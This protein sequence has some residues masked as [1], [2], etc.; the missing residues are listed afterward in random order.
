[1]AYGIAV[2][3]SPFCKAYPRILG[4]LL[5]S[6]SSP[7]PTVRNKSLKSVIQL[8][9]K[10]PSILDRFPSVP[11]KILSCTA[12]PSV[13][14][15]ES[16]LGLLG[17][18]MTMKPALEVEGIKQLIRRT[19]DGSVGVRKRALKLLKEVYLRNIRR[20]TR[21]NCTEPMLKRLE[22]VEESV[23]ELASQTLEELWISS[24]Y[25]AAVEP[26]P[27]PQIKQRL[28]DQVLLM[29][30]VSQRGEHTLPLLALLIGQSLKET[31][32]TA[33]QSRTVCKAMVNIIFD[34]IIDN[35][36]K[37]AQFPKHAFLDVLTVF[38]KADPRL[39]TGDQMS[40]LRPYIS[41]LT[42]GD[43]RAMYRAVIAIY[44]RVLPVLPPL[45]HDFLV[46]VHSDLFQHVSRLSKL[47]LDE[48]TQ[49][50]WIIHG[51]LDNSAK[52]VRLLLS[53]LI[54][55][56]AS[57]RID[58][59]QPS[60]A[61]TLSKTK[62]YI[63]IAGHFG[64][65]MNLDSHLAMFK[66]KLPSYRSDSC[67]GLLV[68]IMLPFTAVAQPISIREVAL[69]NILLVTQSWPKSFLKAQVNTV[70]EG[71]FKSREQRLEL[72]ILLGIKEFFLIEEE[73]SKSGADIAVGDG[74]ASGAER[75]GGSM[76]LTDNDG[77]STAIAQ[78]YLP[79]IMKISLSGLDDLA[80]VATEVITSI[81]RQGLVHPK[82]SC[83]TLVALET[84][85]NSAISNKAFEEHRAQHLK[86]ESMLEKEYLNAVEVAFTYQR[87]LLQD[88]RG[89]T[90]K[91]AAKLWRFYEVLKQG[92][93]ALRKRLLVN[94]CARLN[95]SMTKID[96]VE[97]QL[98]YARFVLENLA[99]FDY[100]RSDEIV[101][102]IGSIEK[103]VTTTGSTVSQRIEA[104]LE[105]TH[106]GDVNQSHV[107]E[108][109]LRELTSASVVLSLFWETRNYLKRAWSLP[110]T[111]LK[112]KSATKDINKAPT[113]LA[114][115]NPDRI[116]LRMAEIVD[117][118]RSADTM[119]AQCRAF[120]DAFMIDH[121]LRVTRSDEDDM[122]LNVTR[123]ETPDQD[124]MDDD[125]ATQHSG[126]SR[127]SASLKRK[128]SVSVTGTPRKRNK[129]QGPKKARAS[130]S[131]NSTVSFDNP[132]EEWV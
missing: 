16:A 18:C 41:H 97:G 71:V 124:A 50:L 31:S 83:S 95:F 89:S 64:K 94:L 128:G 51:V 103:I 45:Q 42:Q 66:E 29:I 76:I 87:G 114:S 6:V 4:T 122:E 39:F 112:T 110:V 68:D 27:S 47:E 19:D 62:R 121:D 106:N 82:D 63:M 86:H 126:G 40:S 10:D 90:S 9:E 91:N 54:G 115:A 85:S 24:F 11:Q 35:D 60:E 22:D 100:G 55:I 44:R 61:Q 125:T 116:I 78:R 53:A 111:N 98:L 58:L 7:Q 57:K 3:N 33:P 48:V 88:S 73:R 5:S 92:S 46:G 109:T 120:F 8:L 119:Q 101:H 17:K 127:K 34:V 81:N 23:A 113:R 69:E 28:R 108:Q 37:G 129:A 118:L 52:L 14:V 123:F 80:L 132:D 13:Q 72:I 30:G 38:A 74:A 77:A 99:L 67:S 70:L 2:F 32:K 102:L 36:Q 93:P 25:E 117:S 1:M 15:R 84:S 96:Q 104:Q 105:S 20:E 130:L 79:Y 49:C 12:D 56:E 59:S 65:N 107:D 131:R 21:V 75:L 26:D 43:D